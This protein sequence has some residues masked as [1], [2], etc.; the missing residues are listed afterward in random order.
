[1]NLDPISVWFGVER[2]KVKAKV[3]VMVNTTA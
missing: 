1:M 3:T 2:S